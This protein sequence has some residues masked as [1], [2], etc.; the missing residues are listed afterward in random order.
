M[1][2][3]GRKKS[4]ERKSQRNLSF[5]AELT[6]CSGWKQKQ[7]FLTF[8][9]FFPEPL[10]GLEAPS[11]CQRLRILLF[12]WI[13]DYVYPLGTV[14]WLR[15]TNGWVGGKVHS[16]PSRLPNSDWFL[17]LT[18]VLVA[19]TEQFSSVTAQQE[20][21]WLSLLGAFRGWT[22]TLK[23]SPDLVLPPPG[24]HSGPYISAFHS[25]LLL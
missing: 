3:E 15:I 14:W 23:L 19:R 16:K 1:R 5:K 11:P 22:M 10:Q 24:N 17:F 18:K 6:L 13:W 12:W 21:E 4:K 9:V 7:G 20:K 2:E 25:H 8:L